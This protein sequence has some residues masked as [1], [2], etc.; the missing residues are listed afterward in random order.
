MQQSH[1]QPFRLALV[2]ARNAPADQ[3]AIKTIRGWGVALDTVA[4]LGGLPKTEVLRTFRPHIFFDDTKSHCDAAAT[5]VS[6][7]LVPNP[8][9]SDARV[10]FLE[11]CSLYTEKPLEQL[12]EFEAWYRTKLAHSTEALQLRFVARFEE[13]RR[14]TAVGLDRRSRGKKDTKT[15]KLVLYLDRLLL[16]LEKHD[17]VE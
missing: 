10:R 8:T 3:R 1:R 4:F 16:Q 14:G 11:S 7:A 9:P 2:T 6:T 5:V 15:N 13:S 17:D 12:A